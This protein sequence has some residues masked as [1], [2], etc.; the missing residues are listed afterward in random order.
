MIAKNQFD[1]LYDQLRVDAFSWYHAHVRLT[2]V[3]KP[4][5]FSTANITLFFAYSSL[6]FF[7]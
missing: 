1:H 5:V 6:C 2:F 7:I 4:A 3:F